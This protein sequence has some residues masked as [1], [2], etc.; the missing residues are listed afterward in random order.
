MAR[1][2]LVRGVPRQEPDVRLWALAIVELVR[3][4]Q[5]EEAAKT[6]DATGNDH[7]ARNAPEVGDD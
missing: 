5:A 4:L 7:P 1:R 3:Q 6:V 2:I